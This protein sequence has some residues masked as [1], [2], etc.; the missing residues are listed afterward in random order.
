MKT[1]INT[2][3]TH[4]TEIDARNGGQAM[5]MLS[6]S[7]QESLALGIH[8]GRGKSLNVWALTVVTAEMIATMAVNVVR[9]LTVAKAGMKF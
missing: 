7:K 6:A 3:C 1:I 2:S 9:I 5:E 8:G 4:F